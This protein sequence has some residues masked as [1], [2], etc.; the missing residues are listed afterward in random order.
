MSL[1][2]K[3]HVD[4]LIM[5]L[6]NTEY[7]YEFPDDVERFRIQLR[8]STKT[9]HIATKIG[10]VAAH[11]LIT[12]SA[13][14]IGSTPANVANGAC[15]VSI[16]GARVTIAAVAAGTALSGANV[17]Q[18]VYGAWALDVTAADV[19]SITPAADNATG[20]ATA[21][22]AIAAIPAVAADKA[23]LGV[24]TAIS[25]SGV[26]NPGTTDLDDAAVTDTYTD[27]DL[28][29]ETNYPYITLRATGA[30]N[31]D[32]IYELGNISGNSGAQ[33]K[34]YFSVLA[35]AQF[36]EVMYWTGRRREH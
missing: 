14:A 3:M 27:A 11:Y 23:R 6:A 36:L 31:E 10:K 20:Y 13:M 21:A 18:D 15:T 8:D 16:A 32:D 34:L 12:A 30:L 28:K 1:G 29:D 33:R 26:F 7:S 22:L 24:V 17:P 5:P 19:K 35:A 4:T 9:L 25:D 2:H